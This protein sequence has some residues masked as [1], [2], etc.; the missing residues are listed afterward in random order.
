MRFQTAII[1][2]AIGSVRLAIASPTPI[3][4]LATR[5]AILETNLGGVLAAAAS[6][7]DDSDV[8]SE[9][10]D[11]HLQEA[12]GRGKGG[13]GGGRNGGGNG[14]GR[15]GKCYRDALASNGK[16]GK[17]K[18]YRDAFPEVYNDIAIQNRAPAAAGAGAAEVL[19]RGDDDDEISSDKLQTDTLGWGRCRRGLDLVDTTGLCCKRGLDGACCNGWI[20][21]RDDDDANDKLQV[22]GWGNSGRCR[23]T[24]SG[25]GRCCVGG[26]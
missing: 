24:L 13:F 23:R 18:C 16:G 6:K 15:K 8:A 14:N 17:G 21:K 26:Y 2:L 7:R 3:D 11:S 4:A 25:I 12:G 10:F 19:E 22:D 5:E 20:L 1:Y 9:S